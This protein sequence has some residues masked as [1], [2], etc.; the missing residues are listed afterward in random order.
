[1]RLTQSLA[2]WGREDFKEVLKKELE[3]LPLDELPLTRALTAGNFVLDDP[4][5][6]LINGIEDD[7]DSITAR[8]GVFF[9]AIEMGDCCI[10]DPSPQTPHQ[11]YSEMEVRIS[12]QDGEAAITLLP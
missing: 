1:M 6:V 11:E 9:S 5:K 7:K 3:S 2:A 8:I 12:K 4:P 10:D